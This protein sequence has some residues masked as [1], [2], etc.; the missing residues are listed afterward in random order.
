MK[1]NG[2]FNPSLR[3]FHGKIHKIK[4]YQNKILLLNSIRKLKSNIL[5]NV[6]PDSSRSD[7]FIPDKTH[8]PGPGYYDQKLFLFIPF[9][10]PNFLFILKY[11]LFLYIIYTLYSMLIFF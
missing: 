8:I 9:F 7:S 5:Q 4:P 11:Y 1:K 2:D 10:H 3:T 6:I